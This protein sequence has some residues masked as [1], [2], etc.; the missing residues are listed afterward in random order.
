VPR[1][2]EAAL[3]RL[4]VTVEEAYVSRSE[5]PAQVA[6]AIDALMRFAAEDATAADLLTK[7][8][9]S[10]ESEKFDAYQRL[11]EYIAGLLS[12]GRLAQSGRAPLP[13]LLEEALAGGIVML[14]VQRLDRGRASELPGL[15]PEVIEFALTPY[16]GS[17]AAK[18]HAGGRRSRPVG[19]PFRYDELRS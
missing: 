9:L 2:H 13:G 12:P 16:L 8:A 4:R 5:W 19:R 17:E 3:G 11:V 14:V 7:E 6:S 18:L 15:A 10:H 1:I